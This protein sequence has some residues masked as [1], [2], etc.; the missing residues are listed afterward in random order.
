METDSANKA[1]KN[2]NFSNNFTL[3]ITNFI[4]LKL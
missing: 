3:L 1:S 4:A 2:E